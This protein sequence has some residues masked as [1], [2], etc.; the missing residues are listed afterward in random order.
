LQWQKH[1]QKGKFPLE[2]ACWPLVEVPVRAPQ[3]FPAEPQT[4]C[5]RRDCDVYWLKFESNA[6]SMEILKYLSWNLLCIWFHANTWKNLH[7]FQDFQVL[8]IRMT[9]VI[10]LKHGNGK[11]TTHIY[12]LEFAVNG[13]PYIHMV[14]IPLPYTALEYRRYIQY[15]IIYS[16]HF[17]FTTEAS[18]ICGTC[19][20]RSL[21]Q[22][23]ND[24]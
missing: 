1:L 13:K 16:I 23:L 6:T 18:L 7:V 9:P 12:K 22:Q 3:L 11:S 2:E 21:A 8:Q 14:D 15:I 4:W 19:Q 20:S 24:T 5:H 17:R 10:F